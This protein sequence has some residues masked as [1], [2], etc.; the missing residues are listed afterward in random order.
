MS[1]LWF[2]ISSMSPFAPAARVSR[3]SARAS[4]HLPAATKQN[5]RS[6][7]WPGSIGSL[8]SVRCFAAMKSRTSWQDWWAYATVRKRFA[9]RFGQSEAGGAS[10]AS[11]VRGESHGDGGE[12]GDGAEGDCG[13][14]A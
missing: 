4:L 9:A 13:G 6:F 3:N 10:R 12:A 1:K 8:G 14:G 7:F 2:A 5:T 11:T